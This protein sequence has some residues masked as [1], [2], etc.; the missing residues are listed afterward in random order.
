MRPPM[1]KRKY[2]N[3]NAFRTNRL[4]CAL[5]P[6]PKTKT[7]PG[8]LPFLKHATTNPTRTQDVHRAVVE[9]DIDGR[10]LSTMVKG[11]LRL[12]ARKAA[13]GSTSRK[14]LYAAVGAL[15][16]GDAGGEWVALHGSECMGVGVVVDGVLLCC[17]VLGPPDVGAI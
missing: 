5:A 17:A 13:L 2:K 10:A 3:N 9:G 8:F 16:G 1:P 12:L 7:L 15:K 6:T 11:E 4:A 14:R